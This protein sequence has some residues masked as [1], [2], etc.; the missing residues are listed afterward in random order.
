[1]AGPSVFVALLRGINV[2]GNNKLPMKELVAIFERAGC[3][4]VRHYIQSG[5]VVFGA[6]EELGRRISSLVAKAIARDHGFEVP[7]IV[8]TAAE[9]RKV[10]KANPFLRGDGDVEPKTLHVMFLADAPA[11]DRASALDA[12]RSPPDAFAIKGREIYLSLPNGAARTK[13]TNAYFDA[14]L[15]TTS[16]AR[17]WNTVLELARMSEEAE[18]DTSLPSA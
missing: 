9:I 18:G 8:R 11:K 7:V 12:N 2:G 1:M 17:N 15:R 3:L 14:A 13:L 16:T 10:A 6:R 4:G 5:N